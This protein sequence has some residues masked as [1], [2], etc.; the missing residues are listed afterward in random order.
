[1]REKGERLEDEADVTLVRR[2]TLHVLA[3]HQDLA[4]IRLL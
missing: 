1:M 4:G 2:H 3:S